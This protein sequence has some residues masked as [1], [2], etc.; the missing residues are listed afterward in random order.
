L[1]AVTTHSYPDEVSLM[2]KMNTHSSLDHMKKAYFQGG[3][4]IATYRSDVTAGL[5]AGKTWANFRALVDAGSFA[6]A[7]A[8]LK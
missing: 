2:S 1:I 7:K 4:N 5:I 6:G 3:A 8:L